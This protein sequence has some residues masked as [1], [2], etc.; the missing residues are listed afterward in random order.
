[1]GSCNFEDGYC[2]WENSEHTDD[3]D[4]MR[5]AGETMS[6]DTGP[7][8]DHTLGTP[9]GLLYY[10]LYYIITV[11]SEHLYHV[12]RCVPSYGSVKPSSR[13]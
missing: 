5:A 8:V 3:F 6:A 4:W 11:E 7:S 9:H 2:T 12:I 13:K 1:M 10:L